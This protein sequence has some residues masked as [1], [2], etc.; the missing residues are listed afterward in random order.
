MIFGA[1]WRNGKLARACRK[2]DPYR[3]V[4]PVRSTER[5]RFSRCIRQPFVWATRSASPSGRDS[6]PTCRTRTRVASP[7]GSTA[8][9]TRVAT[10]QPSSCHVQIS[11][12]GGS[13]STTSPVVVCGVLSAPIQRSCTRPPRRASRSRYDH[14]SRRRSSTVS[15]SQIIS[16]WAAIRVST[17]RSSARA[18]CTGSH[19]RPPRPPA[20]VRPSSTTSPKGR[21]R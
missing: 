12:D 10:G 18:T 3:D 2:A 16:R 14:H 6:H 19:A 4:L 13:I 21:T 20:G 15:A 11:R 7:S 9:S 8:S 5:F 1:R 17:S